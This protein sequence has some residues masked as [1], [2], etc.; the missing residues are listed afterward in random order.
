M[1]G[2]R[3][4]GTPQARSATQD[5]VADMLKQGPPGRGAV[6]AEHPIAGGRKER[7]S[8]GDLNPGVRLTRPPGD[9]QE[10]LPPVAQGRQ[11]RESRGEISARIPS[12]P[13]NAP[14]QVEE[15]P[16]MP[17]MNE[18]QPIARGRRERASRD[19]N[20]SGGLSR[21]PAVPQTLP[22]SGSPTE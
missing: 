17:R 2:L 22:G 21:P 20:P 15:T 14:P 3:I 9:E 1:D 16:T 11:E 7:E 5:A 10:Q 19:E 4:G 12:R 8:R 18:Q 13:P 6:S